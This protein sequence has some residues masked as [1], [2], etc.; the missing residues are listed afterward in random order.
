MIIALVV[1]VGVAVVVASSHETAGNIHGI[2][3][4]H[5]DMEKVTL[6]AIQEPS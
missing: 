1:V 6:E 4:V 3:K 2:A 5:Y